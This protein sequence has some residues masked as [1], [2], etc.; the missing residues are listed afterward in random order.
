MADPV[1]IVMRSKN[2]GNYVARTIA[3]VQ[4]QA[5]PWLG[6]ITLI[7]SGSTDGSLELIRSSGVHRLI[8]IERYVAGE[9][10]NQGMR[11]TSSPWVVYLNADATPA[12]STWLAELMQAA[13]AEPKAGAAFSRQLPRP[14]CWAVYAHDYDRCFGP[15]RESRSWGHFFSMVSSVVRRE[16]WQAQPFRDDLRYAEDDEWSRRLVAH[17]WTVPY[18]E[19]SLAIHSHNYTLREAYKR[20]HGDTFALAATSPTPPRNY[21]YHYTVGLGAL[22]DSLR[23]WTWCAGEGRRREWF[24]AFAVRVAQRLGKRAG[25]RAGWLHYGRGAL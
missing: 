14:D 18:A 15:E 5:G 16:A 21:N 6:R 12:N 2:E 23:D 17:G 8:E 24:R 1:D 3:A 9:V 25:Y 11:E 13:L 19:K 20:S 22:K 7:D 10:L 4:S